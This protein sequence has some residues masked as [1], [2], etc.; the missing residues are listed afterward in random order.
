[1]RERFGTLLLRASIGVVL[2]PVLV[3]QTGAEELANGLHLQHVPVASARTITVALA[4]PVGWQHDPPQRTGTAE[5]MAWWMRFVQR[6]LPEEQQFKV[7]V[8]PRSTL[9][10]HTGTDVSD[11]LE[12]AVRLFAGAWEVTPDLSALAKGKARLEAD[13]HAWLY[14]GSVIEQKAWRT[15]YRGHPAGRQSRGIP[16]QIG[17]L[18]TQ[19]IAARYRQY[20]GTSGASVVVIGNLPPD[21]WDAFRQ[22]I[23]VL[24]ARLGAPQAQVHDDGPALRAVAPHERVDG[25]YV[26][27]AIRAMPPDSEDFPAFLLVMDVL[28][29]ETFEEFGRL[30]GFEWKALFPFL[31]YRYWEDGL[32]VRINRRGPNGS[33][34]VATRLEIEELLARVR[35]GGIRRQ[36]LEPARAEVISTVA[37]PPFSDDLP[38]G[39]FEVRA[40]YLAVALCNGWPLDLAERVAEVT[41]ERANRVLQES[42]APERVSWFALEAL[43]NSYARR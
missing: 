43:A 31:D 1:M 38:D 20:Y 5:T 6:E 27:A 18:S 39:I 36:Q 40:R 23:A 22:S 15:L 4:F 17:E 13:N 2:A 21:R 37:V 33:S 26:T 32:L 35:R 28:R 25:P 3:G 12:R 11:H 29:N 16:E 10:F 34:A 42:L 24:P 9:L 14:P 19:D 30:R 41:S 8:Q 7:M